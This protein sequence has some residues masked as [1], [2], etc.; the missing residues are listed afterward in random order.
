[1]KRLLI[2]ITIVFAIAAVL[3]AAAAT[4]EDLYDNNEEI[5]DTFVIY[6]P[7]PSR[8]WNM[9]IWLADHDIRYT[10]S[11]Y[12]D[13]DLLYMYV[14][15]ITGYGDTDKQAVWT[16]AA[17]ITGTAKSMLLDINNDFQNEYFLKALGL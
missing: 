17:G 4:K 1:M 10:I 8:L 6:D 9:G 2:L 13:A 15:A 5:I 11:K 16:E 3:F 14:I 12:V 7:Y